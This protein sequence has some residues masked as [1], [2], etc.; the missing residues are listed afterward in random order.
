MPLN[1][2]IAFILL[3]LALIAHGQEQKRVAILNTE[4]EGDLTYLTVRLREIAVKAL[5][6][7]S[8][9]IMTAESIIDK[10][11]S[12][13][14]ARKICREAQCLAVIGRKVSAAYVGQAKIGN[15]GGNFT[16]SMELYNSASGTL[17]D[18][19][20]GE[21]NDLRG[22]LKVIDEKAPQMFRKMPG[23]SSNRI[24]EEGIGRLTKS[25]GYELDE[26]KRYLVNLST[27]PSSAVLSFDGV[28]NAKCPKTPCRLELHEGAVRIIAN[29][30]QYEIAD[31]TVSVNQNGQSIF[32]TL[33]PNFGILKINPAY[34]DGIGKDEQWS[35]YI[36]GK[37]APSWE[38]RLSL[39]K[40]KVELLH[41]C[42]ED[43]SF[44]AGI[45]KNKR[46]VFDMAGNITLRKGGLILS[47]ELNGESVSE[48]VFVNGK[49]TGET[50]FSDAVPLCAKVEIGKNR[51]VIDVGLKYNEKVRYTYK[52]IP[53]HI[54][55]T[56]PVPAIGKSIETSF[57]VAIG[58]DV[59]GAAVIVG[60]IVKNQEM[61]K[62]Y[63]R[64][65]ERGQVPEYYEDARREIENNRSSR[66]T[67][68]IIGGVLLAS[69]IGVHI[70]F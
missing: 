37:L 22:L 45:N 40:Y 38:N 16:I 42:Y 19:F 6:K 21:A 43:L 27:E 13:E 60:G 32:I 17:V 11:G 64:Y 52:D 35:L 29:L 2:K 1:C 50:P 23:V 10:L 47:A 9:S 70:W 69:G 3:F 34:I 51:E 5:P 54:S 14:E 68:Y 66:N 41:R 30:E 48:P 56:E 8:Y 39:G 63:D 28:P 4:G 31:T 36:N 46:E 57:L 58:L 24:I 49:Q 53:T 65:S 44:E 18:S 12:I 7:D 59:L 15:F 61:N 62:A 20:T 26:G 25:E 55:R 33:K 67:L